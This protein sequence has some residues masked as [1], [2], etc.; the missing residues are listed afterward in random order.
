[1]RQ[2]MRNSGFLV[3]ILVL[4]A[5]WLTLHGYVREQFSPAGGLEKRIA[6][7]ER[8]KAQADLRSKLALDQLN[9]FRSQVAV[10]L[11]GVIEAKGARDT[12]PLRQLASVVSKGEPLVVERASSAFEKAKAQFREKNFEDA[13]ALL[14]DL[15]A[16]YPESTHIIDAYF[17]LAESEYQTG[18][19][20]KAVDT[21][22]TMIA[23]FPESDLTGFS[24]LRLG[25]IYERQDRL[26]DAADIYRSVLT[27][28]SQPEIVSQASGA[29]KAVAL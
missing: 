17:L 10:V 19:E 9:D 23:L 12:Y 29:L 6:S 28:F 1:M 4:L 5:G 18:E 27:N 3:F 2:V 25:K 7:L 11:P 15:I 24:L 20:E 16:R 13:A 26:E 8:E 22:E 14:I 21:I